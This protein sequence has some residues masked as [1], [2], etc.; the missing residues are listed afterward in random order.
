MGAHLLIIGKLKLLGGGGGHSCFQLLA[1]L[2]CPFVLKLPF[3]A[4]RLPNSCID[5]AVS[6]RFF[7]FRLGHVAMRRH[8]GRWQRAITHLHHRATGNGRRM[9]VLDPSDE[10]LTTI[11]MLTL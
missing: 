10:M 11:S 2:L 4:A 6:I 7:L 8:Y 9:Q 3:V 5:L 1:S